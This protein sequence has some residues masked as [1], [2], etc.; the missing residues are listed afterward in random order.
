MTPT[1]Q[2][3]HAATQIALSELGHR[4]EAWA[5]ARADV[6]IWGALTAKAARNAAAA[7]VPL[8]EIAY[9]ARTSVGI[10]RAWLSMSREVN[11]TSLPPQTPERS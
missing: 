8:P 11:A 3:Q 5:R 4:A 10:V 6:E 2:A 7:G 1:P 9:A